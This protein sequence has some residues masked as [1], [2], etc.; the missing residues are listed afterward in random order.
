MKIEPPVNP[1]TGLGTAK[2]ATERTGA[3]GGAA[4]N[5]PANQPSAT[6]L[7]ASPLASQMRDLQKALAQ[8]GSADIDVAR[9]AEIK[10][11]IAEG[12]L[13]INPDKIASGL[14]DTARELLSTQKS[15]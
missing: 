11:A 10:Q 12:R 15:S 1:L 13:S 9:V 2:A 8:S 6:E 3:A 14:I 4:G 7:S 5:A